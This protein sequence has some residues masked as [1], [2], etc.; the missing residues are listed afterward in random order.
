MIF[1][2]S[3]LVRPLAVLAAATTAVGILA[4]TGTAM[5]SAPVLARPVLAS[6]VPAGAHIAGEKTFTIPARAGHYSLSVGAARIRVVRKAATANAPLTAI[7][8]TLSYTNPTYVQS[9]S[10]PIVEGSAGVTCTAVVS[11]L[12]VGVGLYYNGSLVYDSYAENFNVTTTSVMTK[13]QYSPGYYQIG[14]LASI[15]FPSGYS[16]ATENIGEVYSS[17]ILIDP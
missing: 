13:F 7:N 11:I 9:T 16:P 10:G 8:C 15:E 3:R 17:D 4:M 14:A 1:R 5:A 6:H 12:Y 2:Q